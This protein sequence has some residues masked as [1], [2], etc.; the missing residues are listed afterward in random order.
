MKAVFVS[1]ELRKKFTRSVFL[2]MQDLSGFRWR[3]WCYVHLFSSAYIASLSQQ[4]LHEYLRN[5]KLCLLGKTKHT[6][7]SMSYE[8]ATLVL[9][10]RGG[11]APFCMNLSEPRQCLH[12]V[13]HKERFGV[14]GSEGLRSFLLSINSTKLSGNHVIMHLTMRCC[15]RETDNTH[16]LKLRK[17][18]W[19]QKFKKRGYIE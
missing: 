6:I 10:I 7:R 11:W 14:V 9:K 8:D 3:T 19:W 2:V 16:K 4:K 17:K 13:R 18:Y 5:K 15:I 1:L 12:S